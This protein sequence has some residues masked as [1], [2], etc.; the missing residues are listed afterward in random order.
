MGDNFYVHDPK[1]YNL[2]HDVH[3]LAGTWFSA[4]NPSFAEG[5][6]KEART[7]MSNGDSGRTKLLS[8]RLHPDSA[9]IITRR[10]RMVKED[11]TLEEASRIP[12][13]VCYLAEYLFGPIADSD[14]KDHCCHESV[15]LISAFMRAGDR[16]VNADIREKWE[17]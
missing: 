14:L 2:G 4:K 9:T 3:S 7:H 17:E 13:G 16:L 6:E 1:A 11:I 8:I 15:T 10:A 12:N 5:T